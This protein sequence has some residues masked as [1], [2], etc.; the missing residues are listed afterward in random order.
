MGW[1]LVGIRGVGRSVAD[2]R[3]G[4][5]AWFGFGFR[6]L[7]VDKRGQIPWIWDCCGFGVARVGYLREQDLRLL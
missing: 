5:T 7:D 4:F 1:F 2:Q 3:G 6:R